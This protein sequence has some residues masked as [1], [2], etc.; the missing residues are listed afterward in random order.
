MSDKIPSPWSEEF[1]TGNATK[2]I[3]G[4]ELEHGAIKD[5]YNKAKEGA[6][7]VVDKIIDKAAYK[8]KYK[9]FIYNGTTTGPGGIKTVNLQELLRVRREYPDFDGFTVQERM[10]LGIYDKQQ[11]E[12]AATSQLAKKI[13]AEQTAAKGNTNNAAGKPSNSVAKKQTMV[14]DAENEKK[15]K[16]AAANAAARKGGK[17]RM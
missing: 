3:G 7:K 14:N 15:R 10:A 8:K 1:H 13:Y 2:R 5:T 4:D 11:A 16:Q 9:N 6:Y 12:K 17:D